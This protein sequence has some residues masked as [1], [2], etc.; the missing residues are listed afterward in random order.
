MPLRNLIWIPLALALAGCVSFGLAEGGDP[1]AIVYY[2]LEDAGRPVPAVAPAPRTLLMA[3]TTAGAFYDSDGMAYSS[4][5]GTRGYYQFARW[6]ERSGKRFTDLLLVRL[7]REKIFSA[8]AQSGS[9]VRGEL[10]LTTDIIEFYHDAARQPGTARMELRAEVIDLKTRTLLAR[11]TFAQSIPVSSFDAAGAHKAFNQA[12]T[13]T[14]DE[15]ADWLK[16]LAD[17]S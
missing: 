16:E 2:V 5:S 7:E 8:V 17:K 6:S 13:R 3:D 11:K 9:N 1:R 10:L 15:V 14:L 4:A 12:A